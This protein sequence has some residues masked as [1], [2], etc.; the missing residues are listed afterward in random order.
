MRLPPSP[1]LVVALVALAAPVA[2]A[3]DGAGVQRVAVIALDFEGA[4][5]EAGRELLAQ[6]IVDGL[7]AA[8]FEVLAGAALRGRQA[9]SGA[10]SCS[11]PS[12]YPDLARALGVGYLVSGKIAEQEKTY[13]IRLELLNGKTGATLAS[14]RERCETCGIEDAA[15]R[16]NLAAS[17]LRARLEAVTRMPARFVIQSK[18]AAAKARIDG[19]PAGSTPID[20]EL[21]GGE[22]HL[23]LELAEH[24]PL[25]RTFVAVS[26]VDETLA[27]ELVRRPSP[28]PYRTI[29]W[30][31]LA[32]G[33]LAIGGGIVALVVDGNEISCMQA[34]KD[35]YGNCPRVLNTDILGAVLLGLGSASAAIGG[36]SLY[37]GD[38]IPSEPS[39]RRPTF[40]IAVRGRF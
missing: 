28:F 14:V 33:A 3:E 24:E 36:V 8:R 19:K 4:V 35:I 6:R 31:G 11:A 13:D 37:L 25:N 10:Q 40:G 17:A 30:T 27:F 32:V 7:T 9:D 18:P 29:G 23:T 22:H 1:S 38:R 15:E 5:P 34:R 16:V 12:C 20:L 21:A 39:A 26:G 2:R